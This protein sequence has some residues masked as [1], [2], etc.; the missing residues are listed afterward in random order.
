MQ[1]KISLPPKVRSFRQSLV[2]AGSLVLV[3]AFLM[4]QGFISILFGLGLLF[5]G[6]PRAFRR[7][8]A[9]V[10]SRLLRNLTV[11]FAAIA[12]VF[13]LNWANNRIAASRGDALVAAIKAFQVKHQE[14]P[15][16]LEALV[17]EFIESVPRAKY[18]LLYGHFKYLNSKGS[19]FLYY[20]ALP[21]FGRPTYNFNRGSWGYLD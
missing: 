12:L 6:L 19:T 1:E 7:K 3:D 4:N 2:I 14:Y 18:T 21:P 13:V 5:L 20:T 15:K 17:P 10:R 16:S 9:P 11:Y 8:F